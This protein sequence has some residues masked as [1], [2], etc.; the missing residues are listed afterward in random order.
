MKTKLFVLVF[1]CFVNGNLMKSF[2][3]EIPLLNNNCM[4]QRLQKYECYNTNAFPKIE[5]AENFDNKI[6]KGKSNK[7]NASP[8]VSVNSTEYLEMIKSQIVDNMKYPAKSFQNNIEGFVLVEFK[9]DTIGNI[10]V[11]QTNASN[12]TIENYVISYLENKT[13][14]VIPSNDQILYVK[15]DFK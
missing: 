8:K 3:N 10:E 2:G 14:S 15:F 12:Q 5:N 13:V 11:K 4:T 9:V 7:N 1:L 6:A